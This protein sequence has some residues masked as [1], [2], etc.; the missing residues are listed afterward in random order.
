MLPVFE[1]KH[2][3]DYIDPVKETFRISPYGGSLPDY[4]INDNNKHTK[5]L[6]HYNGEFYRASFHYYLNIHKIYKPGYN[7]IIT[8]DDKLIIFSSHY[9][10]VLIYENIK[11]AFE[12]VF[13]EEFKD[14]TDEQKVLFYFMVLDN[15]DEMDLRL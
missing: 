14:L 5:F 4:V 15:I 6:Y 9:L 10:S 11:N 1:L 8:R 2:D 13:D 3:N 12:N 7:N